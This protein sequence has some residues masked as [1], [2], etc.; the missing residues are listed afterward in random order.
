M[1]EDIE[2]KARDIR[3]KA[4]EQFKISRWPDQEAMNHLFDDVVKDR[5]TF[6]KVVA[7]MEKG[8]RSDNSGLT[9]WDAKN[10]QGQIAC[11][12]FIYFE[13]T[14]DEKGRIKP[15]RTESLVCPA[16]LETSPPKKGP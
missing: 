6:N 11:V 13:R 2:T 7:E 14:K 15:M 16:Q 12:D 9:V 8:N 10:P 5:D 1:S 4:T 3:D